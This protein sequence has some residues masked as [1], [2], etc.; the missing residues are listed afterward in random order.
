MRFQKKLFLVEDRKN[1]RKKRKETQKEV[2]TKTDVDEN[3][4]ENK[5]SQNFESKNNFSL[6]RKKF[7]DALSMSIELKKIVM[8]LALT[9]FVAA[10]N[11][12]HV[13]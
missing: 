9:D 2:S 8:K 11:K 7:C 3:F 6:E 10:I 5:K 4:D 13:A 1:G 12:L